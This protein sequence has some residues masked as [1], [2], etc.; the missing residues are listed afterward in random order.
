[1]NMPAPA[2]YLSSLQKKGVRFWID[3]GQL[4]YHAHK[5]ALSAEDLARLRMMRADIVAELT[6]LAEAPEPGGLELRA[7]SIPAPLSFQQ[8]WLLSLI[9]KHGNW[10]P[11][12]AFAFH[13]AGFLKPQV[14]E[15]SV[16]AILRRHDALR[17]RVV[18]VHGRHRLEM[19]APSNYQ[20]DIVSIPD[21]FA[22][23]ESRSVG[24]HTADLV[25]RGV[26]PAIGP[27]IYVRLLRISDRE[28]YLILV[29]H[30]LVAD[31]MS[32]GQVFR[33]LWLLYGEESQ[34]Q[35]VQLSGQSG[36]YRDYTTWQQA[37]DGQWQQK[38]GAFWRE[39]LHDATRIQWPA[40]GPIPGCE[41]GLTVLQGSFGV[42]LS[43]Q[44]RE[45]GRQ[46]RS[47][48]ALVMLTLYVSAVSRWCGQ[49]DFV[50]PF[51][52][53]GRHAAHDSVVG[54]FS[55]VL[56]LRVRLKADVPFPE[57][58]R[59]ISGEF[60]KAVFHQDL[61]RISLSRPDLLG[62]T[63]CQWLS[64]HPAELA[65]QEVYDVPRQLGISAR[66]V[67]F[68]VAH[69]FSNVPAGATGL[70]VTF[71]ESAGDI[72]VL[73]IFQREVLSE[74]SMERFIHELRVSAERIVNDPTQRSS[75]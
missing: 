2:D 71:F 69:N 75:G 51:N 7:G 9:E 28:H 56:Y 18:S 12:Q 5:G 24:F 58:L 48:P 46:T 16:D 23:E 70:D 66:P 1:M 44:L 65:G 60:Y 62:G 64:W 17:S 31:C 21:V 63:F 19:D 40:E 35:S 42:K 59:L 13:L 50:V 41:H 38:H 6:K 61:G 11:A 49:R 3:K 53:A 47:L 72:G 73:L 55:Q 8:E 33:E 43:A 30:R 34:A 32:I 22:A 15:R 29:F 25:A 36:Q 27:L 39:Y 74:S 52:V 54:C 57:L 45:L 14:L 10:Q 67:H 20:L 26:D 37:G 4:R 68:Q